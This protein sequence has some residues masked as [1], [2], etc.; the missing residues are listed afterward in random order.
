MINESPGYEHEGH[1]S[2]FFRSRRFR[3]GPA[4]F[5]RGETGRETEQPDTDTRPNCA[6]SPAPSTNHR[7]S[8]SDS[9]QLFIDQE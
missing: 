6:R 7:N 2:A 3:T 4:C 5:Y 1:L 9:L 8:I